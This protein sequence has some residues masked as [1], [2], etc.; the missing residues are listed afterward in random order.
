MHVFKCEW[1]LD[2]ISNVNFFLNYE[3]L[4]LYNGHLESNKLKFLFLK[5][6]IKYGRNEYNLQ[7]YL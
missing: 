3:N 5:I 4:E 1:N 7:E 6:K 2:F